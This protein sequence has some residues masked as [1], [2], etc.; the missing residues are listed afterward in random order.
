MDS[1]LH[2]LLLFAVFSKKWID[3][4]EVAPMSFEASGLEFELPEPVKEEETDGR[5]MRNPAPAP[6]KANTVSL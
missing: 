3:Q 1:T 6:F 5:P 2:F 4:T